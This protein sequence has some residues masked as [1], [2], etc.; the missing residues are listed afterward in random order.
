MGG[1]E[2]DESHDWREKKEGT[3]MMA[4]NGVVQAAATA[5]RR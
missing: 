2:S 3:P 5:K 1:D 4:V